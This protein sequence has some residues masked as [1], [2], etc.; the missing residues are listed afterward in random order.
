[1]SSEKIVHEVDGI[2][3]ADNVLPRWWLGILWGTL[4]FA[5]GYWIWYQALGA[6]KS[7]LEQYKEDK[8]AAAKLEAEKLAA[9]G[10]FN[11]EKLVTMSKNLAVVGQGR[12]T[13]TTVCA[14]CHAVNASGNVG[15]N[16]TDKYWL[17]GGKPQQIIATIR[18]G[19]VDKGMPAWLPQLGEQKVRE[20]A[21]YVLSI[22]NTEVPGKAPQ[23]VVE[24]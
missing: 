20:V 14:T 24:E 7:Q 12:T 17:H 3:E 11:E 13:F 1:M 16:L 8:L 5:A 4:I 23:G 22:K 9:D 10:P 15:P 6:G 2:Q 19:V 21:A 18:G